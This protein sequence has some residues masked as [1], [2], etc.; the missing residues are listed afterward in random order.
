[1]KFILFMF[2]SLS[3]LAENVSFKVDALEGSIQS[4]GL[5]PENAQ[6]TLRCQF[7]RNGNLIQ[8][9]EKWPQTRLQNIRREAANFDVKSARVWEFLPGHELLYCSYSLLILARNEAS[10]KLLMGEFTLLGQ[11]SGVMSPEELKQ[12]QDSKWASANIRQKINPLKLKIRGND[13]VIAD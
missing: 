6:V 12:L 5:I 2:I 3:A 11:R 7:A 13:I 10:G 8:E 1:M 9:S 4:P